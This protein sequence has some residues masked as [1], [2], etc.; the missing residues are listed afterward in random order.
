MRGSILAVGFAAFALVTGVASAGTTQRELPIEQAVVQRI[1]EVRAEHG[2]RPLAL[3]SSLTAAAAQHSESMA[4]LGYFTHES[5]DGT[6]FWQRIGQFYG[7]RGY[8]GWSVGENIV[9]GSEPLSADDVVQ[10][11]LD[12]PPHRRNLLSPAWREIGVGVVS[13]T[14]APG[15]FGGDDILLATADFG[16]RHSSR[17][18][19]KQK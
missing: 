13:A 4:D 14:G 10:A 1:N 15:V 8:T 5:H 16:V 17:R 3:S 11:W 2:L 18:V 7:T 9:F 6:V 19:P 12:S